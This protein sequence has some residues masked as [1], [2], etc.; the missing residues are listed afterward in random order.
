[1]KN[2]SLAIA[3]TT[4]VLIIYSGSLPGQ[5][6]LKV[7]NL[8]ESLPNI[9]LEEKTPQK[10]L[11]VIDN[12]D[13]DLY[14]NFNRKKRVTGEYTRG[15]KN[16]YVKWNNVR[17]ADSQKLNETFTEGEKQNHM[18]NFSY[19][20]SEEIVNESFFKGIAEDDLHIKT[21]VWD[22]L[23]FELFAWRFWNILKLNQEYSPMEMNSVIQIERLGTFENKDIRITWAGITKK[24]DKLCAAIKFHSMNNPLNFAIHNIE[25]Q[26]R[27]HY[28]GNIYVSLSDKQIEYGELYEDLVMDIK[29]IGHVTGNKVN[30]VRNI[31]IEKIL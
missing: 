8:L 2:N 25:I 19:V 9:E 16:G 11:M 6:T 3:L 31:S 7:N 4:V 21:L 13:Y 23:T 28:W 18:E 29:I 30:T 17:V 27:S 15:L 5:K 14:G 26:G 22:M 24:N 10:Y 12:L 1:M 20:A